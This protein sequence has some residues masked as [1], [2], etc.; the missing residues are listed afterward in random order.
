L[1]KL[2]LLAELENTQGWAGAPGAFNDYATRLLYGDFLAALSA[3][4]TDYYSALLL[5]EL[6]AITSVTDCGNRPDGT[7]DAAVVVVLTTKATAM[8]QLARSNNALEQNARPAASV[9]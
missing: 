1:A 2:R 3:D 8:L 9:R 4:P 6:I 7:P 5:D